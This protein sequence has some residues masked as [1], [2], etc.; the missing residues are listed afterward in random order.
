MMKLLRFHST[1]T[2]RDGSRGIHLGGKTAPT[3]QGPAESLPFLQVKLKEW[4][5]G[6]SVRLSHLT[7]S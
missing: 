1:G 5:R 2:G 7:M 4:L 6:F 3:F